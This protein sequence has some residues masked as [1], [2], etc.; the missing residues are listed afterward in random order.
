MICCFPRLRV[1]AALKRQTADSFAAQST[2]GFPRLRVVAALKRYHL[3][4]S[5]KWKS[6]VFHDFVSWPH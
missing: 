4:F 1:V 5:N 6:I 2:T 3:L